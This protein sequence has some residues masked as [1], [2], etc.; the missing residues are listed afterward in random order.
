MIRFEL[1]KDCSTNMLRCFEDERAIASEET[2]LK[3]RGH[4][5]LNYFLCVCFILFYFSVSVLTFLYRY[6]FNG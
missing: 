6:K 5:I 1:R 3:T 2:T 4:G